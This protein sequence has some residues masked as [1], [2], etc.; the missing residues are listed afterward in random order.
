MNQKTNPFEKSWPQIQELYCQQGVEKL[1]S[2][3][4]QSEDRLERRALY[5]MASQ[6]ISNGQG[7]SRSLDDVIGIC[8]AAIDEFSCQSRQSWAHRIPSSKCFEVLGSVS[9]G[10]QGARSAARL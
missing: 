2:H 10:Q 5:L 1:I 8:R 4:H 7:L 3:I 6:R 9:S